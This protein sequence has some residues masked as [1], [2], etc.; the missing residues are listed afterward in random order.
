MCS[1]L[2]DVLCTRGTSIKAVIVWVQKRGA[3]V[4]TSTIFFRLLYASVVLPS[5]YSL[6]MVHHG[7]HLFPDTGNY[8]GLI[9]F[10]FTGV[11]RNE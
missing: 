9:F 11:I 5:T 6:L 3:K 1:L 2:Y 10:H 7:W 8:W 4:H